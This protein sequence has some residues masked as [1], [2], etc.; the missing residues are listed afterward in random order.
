MAAL[1]GLL[2]TASAADIHDVW[3]RAPDRR[4]LR[5]PG[6]DFAE[7]ERDGWLRMH[8]TD[9]GLARLTD[10]GLPWVSAP[11][12]P[13]GIAVGYRSPDEMV[14]ALELLAESYPSLVTLVDLGL[15]REGRPIVGVTLTA[16]ETPSAHWRLLGTHHGD[17][18]PTGEVVLAVAEA[19]AEGYDADPDLTALLDDSAVV[20]VPHV[21]PDGLARLSRYSASGVDLNRNY[22]HEWRAE[23][24]GAG[25][26]PFSEPETRA[27]RTLSQWNP[28]HAGLSLH[29]GA[30]NIGWVWNHTTDDAPDRALLEDIAARYAARVGDPDFWITN[31]A[32]WYITNGD[33]TDWTYG[34]LGT[35]DFTV[36]VSADKTPPVEELAGIIDDCLPAM[37]DFLLDPLLVTGQ[38]RD[39]QTG[40]GIPATITLDG[41]PL[42]SGPQGHFSR[43]VSDDGGWSITA[44]APGYATQTVTATLDAPAS[45]Q[46]QPVALSQARPA[47]ALL[48]GPDARFVLP[49]QSVL[50]TLPGEDPV[51]PERRDGIWRLDT[52]HLAPGPWTITVDGQVIPRG[53]LIAEE[54]EHTGLTAVSHDDRLLWL[55]GAGLGRGS[56][57]YALLGPERALQPLSVR[58]RSDTAIALD[59]LR[60]P[61]N[62]GPVD[63]VLISNGVVLMVS[64]ALGTPLFL[65]ASRSDDQTSERSRRTCAST[66]PPSSLFLIVLT[67]GLIARR[68]P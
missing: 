68:Q 51:R 62:D 11:P 19:L 66:T 28:F 2:L 32:D 36:E 67:L 24:L 63:I 43:A 29:A 35:L 6:V 59:I 21:N 13:P 14:E 38:V 3:V 10:A 23:S 18:L 53:L 4:A 31:G 37:L 17:E 49:G 48:A 41:Q 61:D 12:P 9:A 45:I 60:L 55:S 46:L 39:A 54:S 44:Q 25:P 15:S 40:R 16:A 30:T 58:A 47:P 5:L 8:A 22:G 50:L 52:T 57:A 33:S 34:R 26:A 42:S 1:L 65:S 20:L 27:I 64:D 56:R 7:G